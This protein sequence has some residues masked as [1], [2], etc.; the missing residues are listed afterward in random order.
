MLTFGQTIAFLS[1]ALIEDELKSGLLMKR[2][3]EDEILNRKIQLIYPK[4]RLDSKIDS[5][6]KSSIYDLAKQ[7]KI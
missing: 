4:S 5:F 1:V 2:D 3:L 7:L 6:V